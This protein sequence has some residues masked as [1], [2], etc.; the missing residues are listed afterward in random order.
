MDKRTVLPPPGRG[1]QPRVTTEDQPK[2]KRASDYLV[3][4]CACTFFLCMAA[5]GVV[6]TYKLI[7]MMLQ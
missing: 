5:L 6:G 7:M 3:E 2:R 1:H 4:L